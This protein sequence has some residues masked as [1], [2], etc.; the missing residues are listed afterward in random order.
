M[1][2]KLPNCPCSPG[3]GEGLSEPDICSGSEPFVTSKMILPVKPLFDPESP[4]GLSTMAT[5]RAILKSSILLDGGERSI[6]F[7][8]GS[9]ANRFQS[10]ENRGENRTTGIYGPIP[11]ALF[12]KSGP[13]S[14]FW[15]TSRGSL[16][17]D[18]S[19]QFSGTFPPSGSMRN[20]R[21]FQRNNAAL[22][23]E[24]SAFGF[25]PTPRAQS[26]TGARPNPSEG[27]LGLQT[28]VKL[29]PTPCSYDATPGGPNNHYK[30]LGNM[31]T[32]DPGALEDRPTRRA[33]GRLYPTPT[34]DGLDG[35]SNSRAAAKRRG[36]YPTPTER[37]GTNPKTGRG[38]GLRLFL[39]ELWP[40][41][42]A[43]EYKGS[44][45]KGSKSQQ[46]RLDRKYLDATVEECD[47]DPGPE[48]RQLNPD[49][50]E[51]L[52]GWPIGWTS[53]EPLRSLR[54]LPWGDDPADRDEIPRLV[55]S[56]PGR[57]GR[58]KALGNGQ[59]PMTAAL[60][61]VVLFKRAGG[62]IYEQKLRNDRPVPEGTLP[63]QD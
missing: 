41:P 7:P 49:W 36:R 4:T 25:W 28:K 42:R 13:G 34:T 48:R 39:Q 8:A 51:W 5:F 15:K 20:G 56:Y 32:H 43:S 44:G 54:W 38:G 2:N 53:T 19:E 52:M 29:F 17:P 62:F 14:F 59:V 40:T 31:A 47:G 35:G 22:I 55:K 11:F 9:P 50:V 23:I 12:E 63:G 46:C 21:L 3:A 58:I 24:G 33:D 1:E 18:T 27:G 10:P 26:A 30:G 57:A 16:L 6:S 45:P 37:S 61:F 60:A